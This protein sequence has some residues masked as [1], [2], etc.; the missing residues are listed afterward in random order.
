MTSTDT[1][2]A[3]AELQPDRTYVAA[4]VSALQ[5]LDGLL[6]QALEAA[7]QLHGVEA[8]DDL[9]RG[10]YVSP[11]EVE[12]LLAREPA[13]PLL[14]AAEV[15]AATRLAPTGEPETRLD[16]LWRGLNL[17]A[18]EIDL[19]LLALAPELDRRYERLYAYLQDHVS[20]RRPSIDL[21]LNLLCPDVAAK[22]DRRRHFD[23]EAPLRRFH[24]I[25]LVPPPNTDNPTFLAQQFMLDPQIVRFLL[26]QDT[27]D[28]RLTR[29]TELLSPFDNLTESPLAAEPQRRLLSLIEQAWQSGQP[30]R[31][32]FQGPPETGQRET[33]AGLAGALGLPL[34]VVDLAQVLAHST[35]SREIFQLIFREAWLHNAL[36]YLE[37]ADAL[38][39]AQNLPAGKPFWS[40]LAADSGVTVLSGTQSWALA[41]PEPLGLIPIRFERPNFVQRRT[42]WETRLAELGLSLTPAELDKLA[43]RFRLTAPQMAEAALTAHQTTRL[44]PVVPGQNGQT[45]NHD[46]RLSEALFAAARAQSSQQLAA[47]AHKI[48]PRYR[49]ADL[50]LPDDSLRQLREI[51]QRVAQR[52]RV[53]ADWGFEHKLSLGKGVNALFAGP[54]GTGKTMAAEIIAHELGLDLYKIDLSGVVSKY[55]GE[56]EKNLDR[57]F[58][59]AEDSNAILF[60]DEADALFGKRSEVRDS[61]DRYANIEISYLLQKM[62]SYDGIAILT[63]NLRQN[64][65]DAF[66]RRMAFTVHFPFPDE[67]S[68][69]RIWQGIWPAAAPL[70]AEVDLAGLAHQFKLSGGNIK[71]VALAA[72]FLAA[73]AGDRIEAQ[74]VRQAIRREYQKMGKSIPETELAERLGDRH[75]AE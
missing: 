10:L 63:T 49:W 21:A 26:H 17:A 23:P 66:V 4:L 50:V 72:A 30:L 67:Q 37:G 40:L 24:L 1:I 65:D 68:R 69:L 18:F 46:P 27:L 52:H 8:A 14:Y 62:E 44:Q 64:L 28:E 12:R 51:C 29:F 43:G 36:L 13:T 75:G 32:Y 71:N 5:R 34:L 38:R 39:E 59:A 42:C 54:S 16:R 48:S 58:T 33:M 61:H 19:I 6:Q 22:L 20:C 53:F 47:L 57:I 7:P 31:L 70:A 25:Q 60:F 3:E 41:G 73:E 2:L 74:H 15:D 35:D 55:I 56:T 9:Y 11:Q 45:K